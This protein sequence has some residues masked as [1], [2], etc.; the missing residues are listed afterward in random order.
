MIEYSFDTMQ[1]DIASLTA[2]NNVQLLYI[3]DNSGVGKGHIVHR[4][5]KSSTC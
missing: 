2:M 3:R 4:F 5:E 1:E